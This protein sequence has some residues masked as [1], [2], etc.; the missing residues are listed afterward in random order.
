MTRVAALLGLFLLGVFSLLPPD[1]YGQTTEPEPSAFSSVTLPPAGTYSEPVRI[2][3]FAFSF[4]QLCE[5]RFS[6]TQSWVLLDK[7][8]TLDSFPGEKR[9]YTVYIRQRNNPELTVR[10][11]DYTINRM[12]PEAPRFVTE[13]GDIYGQLKLDFDM[14]LLQ[15]GSRI[16]V[17]HD[18]STG[19]VE[20]NP[21]QP[22]RY[23]AYPDRTWELTVAAYTQNA[24]GK[25]GPI[26][27]RTWRLLPEGF[28]PSFPFKAIDSALKLPFVQLD[29]DDSNLSARL[30][31]RSDTQLYLEIG[32]TAELLYCAFG[33]NIPTDLSSFANFVVSSGKTVLAIP[34]PANYAEEVQLYIAQQEA[35]SIVYR[36]LV[37]T[38]EEIENLPIS[39]QAHTSSNILSSHAPEIKLLDNG[40]LISWNDPHNSLMY[41]LNN[42]G[43]TEYE[44]PFVLPFKLQESRLAWYAYNNESGA[45][46]A[47]HVQTL[48][49][50]Q[51]R[52]EPE[53]YGV[54]NNGMYG[55]TVRLLAESPETIRYS[56]GINQTAAAVNQNSELMAS[57]LEFSVPEGQTDNFQVRLV[58]FDAAGTPGQERLLQFSLNGIMPTPPGISVIGDVQNNNSFILSF[59]TADN[60][61]V[62][63]RIHAEGSAPLD[64]VKYREPVLVNSNSGKR[65]AYS[66][67]AYSV[68][69][70]GNRSKLD[71]MATYILDPQSIYVDTGSQV[72]GDGSPM[73]PFANLKDALELSSRSLRKRILIHGDLIC[74]ATLLIN[75]EVEI[76]GGY[77]E[78][79]SEGVGTYSNL[80]LHADYHPSAPI[81]QLNQASCTLANL[82]LSIDRP[83]SGSSVFAIISSDFNLRNVMLDF[84]GEIDSPWINALDSDFN[85]ANVK[86]TVDKAITTRLFSF[87]AVNL[88]VNGLQLQ[89]SSSIRFFELVMAEQSQLILDRVQAG[90]NPAMAFSGF[91]LQNSRLELSNSVMSIQNGSSS[92][93]LIRAL[94]SDVSWVNNYV[95]LNWNGNSELF[96]LQNDSDAHVFSST[97]IIQGRSTLF[98]SLNKSR[99]LLVNSII[100]NS[101][102]EGIFLQ[103]ANQNDFFVT[104][105]CF[106]G[107]ANWV[108]GAVSMPT[109]AILNESMQKATPLAAL[110]SGLAEAPVF[111][112]NFIEDPAQTF[113]PVEKGMR[114]LSPRSRCN[115]SAVLFDVFR[116]PHIGHQIIQ[117]K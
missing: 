108:Q 32:S 100:S 40:W 21:L 116:Y 56:V 45:R 71:A 11:Y 90:F 99:L 53:L 86:V 18:A 64:Y 110:F 43:E 19:F 7:I 117:G 63:Y 25:T 102:L 47:L 73:A 92:C 74:T 79:W 42:S 44:T 70:Y 39:Q 12:R 93:R 91:N 13:A 94:G 3:P 9:G 104:S 27:V 36:R 66:I 81:L 113:L 1:A 83:A 51:R 115:G 105:N 33:E 95:S 111:M 30:L 15:A 65:Q 55:R 109:L 101:A 5:Y 4:N 23:L 97:F 6:E 37:Y 77:T 75:S 14:D 61:E 89:V 50:P 24:E 103:T 34:Y 60:N 69:Q 38:S 98:G 67:Q 114:F 58:P 41:N 22:P 16:F 106:W 49:V 20:F 72:P 29:S 8:L 68:D 87:T 48:F 52:F 28:S 26:S 88:V 54:V 84:S 57:S 62:Y 82:R 107:F 10:R 59:T 76:I 31:N 2:I 85:M 17:C 35:S 46:T 112:T 80:S 96:L 78:N